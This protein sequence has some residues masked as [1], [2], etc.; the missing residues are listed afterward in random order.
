MKDKIIKNKNR[1][2]SISLLI[3]VSLIG[4]IT[5]F[6]NDFDNSKVTD[7]LAIDN[8]YI[9]DDTIRAIK[10]QEYDYLNAD[11]QL[12]AKGI[13]DASKIDNAKVK[14][15]DDNTSVITFKSKK[16][17]KIMLIKLMVFILMIVLQFKMQKMKQQV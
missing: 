7:K 12:I 2:I 13:V 11:K 17:L 4:I 16:M 15:L 5:V 3:M 14:V 1:I 10:H 9:Q 6:T 8:E